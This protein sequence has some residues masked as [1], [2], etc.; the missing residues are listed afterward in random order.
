M[1]EILGEEHEGIE[2]GGLQLFEEPVDVGSV[3]IGTEDSGRDPGF[4]QHDPGEEPLVRPVHPDPAT[5]ARTAGAG[6]MNVAVDPAHGE[7]VVSGWGPDP[8]PRSLP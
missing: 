6:E 7:R 3:E 2:F 8:K 1:G 5:A 4:P